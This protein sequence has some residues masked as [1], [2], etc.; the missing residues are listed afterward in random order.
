MIG[1]NDYRDTIT[2][3]RLRKI[4]FCIVL[5]VFQIFVSVSFSPLVICYLA[6]DM[7]GDKWLSTAL[8][9]N[10]KAK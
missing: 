6:M 4:E 5:G 9:N 8:L 10:E 3:L 7:T 2:D 1:L